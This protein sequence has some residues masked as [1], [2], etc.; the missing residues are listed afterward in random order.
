MDVIQF[1]ITDR[2]LPGCIDGSILDGCSITVKSGRRSNHEIVRP[3]DSHESSP[4]LNDDRRETVE[5]RSRNDEIHTHAVPRLPNGQ[6]FPFPPTIAAI[7]ACATY[8]LRHDET[9][10]I[11][12][13][14]D[15]LQL[16]AHL[17]GCCH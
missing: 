12:Y 4:Q 6:L 14:S 2:V 3:L 11:V 17:L 8:G 1:G 13:Q 5:A 7:V 10:G 16:A 9:H 15:F